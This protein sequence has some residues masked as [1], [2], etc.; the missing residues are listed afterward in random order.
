[1]MGRS[2]NRRFDS[3]R[4]LHPRRQRRRSFAFT[5]LELMLSL[6]LTA[7]V[8]ITVNMAVSLNLRLFESRRSYLEE[9]QLAREVLRLVADD[10]RGAVAPHEQDVSS[11]MQLLSSSMGGSSSTGGSSTGTGT[12]TGTGAG[13]GTGGQQGG[14]GGGQQG[15]TGGSGQQG[16][17]GSEDSG[18]G[19]MDDAAELLGESDMSSS[20]ESLS[21]AVSVPATPGIYGNQYELQIDVSRL[22][23]QDQ[24]FPDVKE[25]AVTSIVDIPSD[26]KTVT[27]YILNNDSTV[28]TDKPTIAATDLSQASNPNVVGHGLV[29]RQLDRC[30]T[31]WAVNNGN[32]ATLATEG[33]VVAPEA[34]SIEFMYFDGTD[35][36]TEWDSESQ[37][38]LPIAIQIILGFGDIA[39]F[40]DTASQTM[41]APAG[42]TQNIRYYRTIVS[43][44]A[45]QNLQQGSTDSTGTE[46][47]DTESG[48]SGSTGA[49]GTGATGS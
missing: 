15:G 48:S 4:S 28:V 41:T 18:A 16:G 6:S 33:E 12:G 26:V 24:F 29:R 19:S 32:A 30:V 38:G 44:P 42:N 11:V 1:M 23:R 36:L 9:S 37:G 22:P 2:G 49:S 21:S 17:T 7:V 8:L 20:T 14:T 35:W 43:V 27:Y 13:T 47:T 3:A 34:I 31:E 25:N 10:I 46:S 39:D 5:L 45:A 40:R